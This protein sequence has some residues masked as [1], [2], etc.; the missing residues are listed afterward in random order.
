MK[1]AE[2][3]ENRIC[4]YCEFST[5]ISES[6]VC[7]CEKYGVVSA[8]NVCK[9]FSLDLLKVTPRKPKPLESSDTVITG[10]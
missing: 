7:V 8:D 5:R 6:D 9:K 1:K 4:F 3:E 2:I 10:I